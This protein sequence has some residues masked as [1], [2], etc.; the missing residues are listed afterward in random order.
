MANLQVK[1]MSDDL[2]AQIKA[3]AGSENRSVSQQILF[4]TKEYLFE[5]AAR[6]G[7][8]DA[9]SGSS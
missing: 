8:E 1:G 6:A 4:M 7:R 5:K 2:Y 3:L 9:S